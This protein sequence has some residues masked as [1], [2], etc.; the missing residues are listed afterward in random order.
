VLVGTDTLSVGQNLQDARVVFHL[1]LTW[2]PMVLEQRIGRLDRPR[3]EKDDAPIEIRYFLNLDLIEA[4][5]QLKKTIDARLEATYRDTAFDDEILP[6]YFDLIE[7]MRKLRKERADADEIAR[8]VDALLQELATARPADV[9]DVNI[10]SRR[11]A[12][13]KLR[14]A[15]AGLSLPESL[16]PTALTV[17]LV[18]GDAPELAAEIECHAFDNNDAMIGR[19]TQHLVRLRLTKESSEVMIDDLVGTVGAM[20]KPPHP[21]FGQSPSVVQMLHGFDENVQ[22]VAARVRNERNRLR[23][24]QREIRER[25]RPPWLVPLVQSIRSFLERLPESQYEAFLSRH[26]VSDEQL[27]AWL[28]AVASGVDLDDREM[29]ERLRQLEHSPSTILNEF[30][31]LRELV[32]EEKASVGADNASSAPPPAQLDLVLEPIVHRLEARVRNIR[33]NLPAALSA[34][35]SSPPKE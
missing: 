23:E 17:G 1:D 27:G 9:S 10:E 25:T 33:I 7:A 20:L 18:D 32:A 22:V 24:K 26:G 3:H 31:A 2:N 16:P 12:L 15:V 5:L 30:G 28:D 14:D 8:E 6:G 4:E 34:M 29:I 21:V 11:D 19:P 13:N 35:S